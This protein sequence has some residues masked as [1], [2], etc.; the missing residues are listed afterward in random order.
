MNQKREDKFRGFG[1]VEASDLLGRLGRF[2]ENPSQ[3]IVNLLAAQC[4]LGGADS[5][6]ILRAIQGGRGEWMSW[7][8]I[9]CLKG[10]QRYRHG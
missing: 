4:L 8:Y 3:F 10:K 7:H 9:H 1:R 2:D 6:A 5:G